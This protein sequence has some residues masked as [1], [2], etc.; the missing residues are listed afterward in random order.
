MAT[1]QT[2]VKAKPSGRQKSKRLIVPLDSTLNYSIN[3]GAAAAGVSSTTIWRAVYSGNL[4]T[5]RAG[6]RRIISGAQIKAWLEAGGKTGRTSKIE[7]GGE[8][9]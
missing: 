5:Y 8:Q 9:A 1:T 6:R 4:E 7:K 3:D 2:A